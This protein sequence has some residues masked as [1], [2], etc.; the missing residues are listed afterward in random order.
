M[1][2]QVGVARKTDFDKPC[3]FKWSGTA[4]IVV[5]YGDFPEENF[6]VPHLLDLQNGEWVVTLHLPPG[7]YSFK[8]LVDGEY[9]QDHRLPSISST[10]TI[11]VS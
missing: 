6:Q 2:K 10:H 3:T 4:G 7:T 5:L 9:K 1:L 8:Y 11:V